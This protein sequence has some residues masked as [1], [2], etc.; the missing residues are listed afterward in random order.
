M[1]LGGFEVEPWD[2]WADYSKRSPGMVRYELSKAKF[3]GKNLEWPRRELALM[4]AKLAFVLQKQ[5]PRHR[6]M[7]TDEMRRLLNF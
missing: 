1:R 3:K 5:V 7:T 4:L 6:R 2:V